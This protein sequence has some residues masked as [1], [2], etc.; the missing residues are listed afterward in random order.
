M[1]NQIRTDGRTDKEIRIIAMENISNLTDK[2]LDRWQNEISKN[3]YGKKKLA[4][5]GKACRGRKA[6]YNV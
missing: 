5:G 4:F 2:Q 6:N 3:V 1:A